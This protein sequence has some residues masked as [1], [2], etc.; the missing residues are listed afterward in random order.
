MNMDPVAFR[1]LN[2]GSDQGWLIALD[3]VAKA[4]NWQPKVPASNLQSA[5]IVT[6][7][8]IALGSEITSY[9]G[10]VADI[11]VNKKTGKIT[12]KHLTAALNAGL[13]VNPAAIEN[14]MS[15]QQVQGTSRALVEAMPFTK[16]HV[17][18][19]DWVSY[20]ILR[21][22]DSPTVTTVVLQQLN[23]PP[24]GAGEEAMAPVPGAIANAFFDAT[25]ARIYQY[26]MTPAH[27]REALKAAGV[28]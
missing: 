11:T 3:G 21:F 5:D 26:P 1:Q 14:Q 28:A 16:S 13:A 19:L 20:P 27:V 22:Q 9:A 18:G 7:R 6:G 4:A 15:G 24:S 10:V 17:T 25:G 12:V 23:Q 2:M 8:G